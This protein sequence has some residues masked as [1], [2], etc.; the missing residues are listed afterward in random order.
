MYSTIL[1]KKLALP[2]LYRKSTIVVDAISAYEKNAKSNSR[3]SSVAAIYTNKPS[4]LW[5]PNLAAVVSCRRHYCSSK[6]YR[7]FPNVPEFPPVVWPNLFKSIKALLYTYLI[8]KP[9][10]DSEFSLGE[11]AKNSRKVL[12]WYTYMFIIY[13]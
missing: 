5:R 1:F 9:Q 3:L 4:F 8:I 6:N 11:F 10:F 12:D 13:T 2:D 7:P